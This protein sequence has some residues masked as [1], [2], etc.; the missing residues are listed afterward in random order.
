MQMQVGS[1]QENF[2]LM[3]IRIR[4]LQAQVASLKNSYS[5]ILADDDEAGVLD[6][7]PNLCTDPCLV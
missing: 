7:I 6:K 2:E 1:L 3:E 4:S 5:A